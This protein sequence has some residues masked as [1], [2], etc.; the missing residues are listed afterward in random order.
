MAAACSSSDVEA[1]MEF[2]RKNGF[3]EVESAL[4]E[5][6]MEKC[7]FG[8]F[9]YEKF[10]FPVL[11]PVRIPTTLR[12]LEVEENIGGDERSS[13]SS[14]V[15][16][17]DDDEFVSV[18]SSTTGACSSD[19]TN[20][21]GRHSASQG[22]SDASSDSL[23]QFDT[24]RDY[25]D[26]DMQ[27]DIY[28][29]DVKDEGC[30][31]TPCFGGPDFFGCTSEDKFITTSDTEKP[32]ENS[33]AVYDQSEGLQSETSI[34][35]LDKP[36]LLSIPRLN[37]KNEFQVT[38]YSDSDKK[39]QHE[40]IMEDMLKNCATYGCS[41]TLVY[42]ENLED[43]GFLISKETDLYDLQMKV[44]G[45]SSTDCDLSFHHGN[46]KTSGYSINRHSS[47]EWIEGF[48]DASNFHVKDIK[49][50]FMSN[51]IDGYDIGDFK[52]NG[53]N[54]S[55]ADE[56]GEDVNAN[57]LLMCDN[58]EEE[59]E[60]FNLRIIH[61]KNRT[62]FEEN[63]DLH[64]VLNTVIAGRYYVTEYLGSAAF[65]KVFQAHDLHTGLDVCLKII[66]NDKD[67]FDQSLDEIKLLKLVNQHD[68]GD[69]HHIL[70]LFDYF[71]HQEHLFIVC[72]LLRANLY[73]FQKFNQESGGEA[74]FSLSRLQLI[75][76][77]CLEAL[78]YLHNLGIL[79]C[80]L[81]P[82][83]I[84]LKSYKRC[85]IKIIDLGSSCFVT[86]NL[87]LYVQSRSYRAPE[88][89]LGLPYDQ[90]IDLWS[91][92]CILAEL[93]SGEV[94]FPNDAVAMILARMIG[95]LGPIDLDML[96]NGQ[97]TYK[98]FTKEYDLFFETDQ[99]E[100]II[101]EEYSL[102][103]QLQVSDAKFIDFIRNLLEINPLRRPTAREALEHPWLSHSY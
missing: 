56:D 73:E 45:D 9:D 40:E 88:V 14:F 87:C 4:K 90:K 37:D 76:R 28:W 52:F 86:D 67:F 15:S 32:F 69:E 55:K 46:K 27:S 17:D 38:D 47:N 53:L 82:E 97:E 42:G 77:Q 20:P 34:D 85:E 43:Y 62:G 44:V 5:D 81:K 41:E 6:M 29:R 75:T 68:P 36:C 80:D 60:I 25:P 18:G 63:K 2:L 22:N 84:L 91:L 33:L 96:V 10:L 11:P 24:A 94:L 8:S 83:N 16:S 98:Y 89:I 26:Y 54:E 99:L 12:R 57:D 101:P 70:R 102:E 95:M 78:E 23:S 58:H 65:S 59:Y 66:K 50:D 100:Y 35:Y 71:Y 79:H 103:H 39:N 1:V 51:G 19:F 7:D 3:K 92:G 49:K 48:K 93:C 61:R 13:R 64:I 72:E 74:Y 30:F 21:Y 31:L